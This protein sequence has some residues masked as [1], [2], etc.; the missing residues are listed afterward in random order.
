MIGSLTMKFPHI[1]KSLTVGPHEIA[2]VRGPLED[3]GQFSFGDLEIRIND[4]LKPSAQFETLTHEIF[5]AINLVYE[6]GLPHRSIQILG[7]AMAQV[8]KSAK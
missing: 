7:A 3:A 4:G 6:L 2:V 1:P 5:E 8:I